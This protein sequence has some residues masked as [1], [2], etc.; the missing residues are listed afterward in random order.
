MVTIPIRYRHTDLVLIR[1]TTDPGD[2]DPPTH[3][4]LSQPAT[5][6]QE[7]RAWLTKVWARDEIR[8]A[9]TL[10]SPDLA[11]TINRLLDADPATVKQLRR[12]VLSVASY[13]CAGSAARH[14][15]ACSPV[16]A[17]SRWGLRRPRS[18]PDTGSSR[19]PT[20]AGSHA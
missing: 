13:P 5:V 14:R 16:S 2:L 19:A 8:Q 18:T 12:A 3:L 10:A 6:E 1:A 17:P 9:L 7:G 11:S 15:S 20:E 4:D